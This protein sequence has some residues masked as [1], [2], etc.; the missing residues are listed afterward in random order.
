MWANDDGIFNDFFI[1][2]LPPS[3]TVKNFEDRLRFGKVTAKK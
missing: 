1:A 2:N 3:V